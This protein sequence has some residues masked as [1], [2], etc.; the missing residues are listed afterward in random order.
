MKWYFLCVV[1]MSMIIWIC[2]MYCIYTSSLSHMY[3]F[4]FNRFWLSSG[5]NL[6]LQSTLLFILVFETDFGLIYLGLDICL[7]I[8][9][10]SHWNSE[11]ILHKFMFFQA[12]RGVV[13]G[14]NDNLTIINCSHITTE[15]SASVAKIWSH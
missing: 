10:N 9:N 8:R 4:V 14:L 15:N 3:I 13:C 5:L 7:K 6:H 12:R 1:S 2:T 11:H